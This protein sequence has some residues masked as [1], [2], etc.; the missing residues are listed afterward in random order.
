MAYTDEQKAHTVELYRTEGMAAAHRETGVPK[1]SIKRWADERGVKTE[2]SDEQTK[3]ATEAHV[4]AMAEERR[5]TRAK[6]ARSTQTLLDR[7]EDED[8]PSKCQSLAV[9]AAILV[10]KWQ[11]IGWGDGE[12]AATNATPELERMR[13][14][15]VAR[16]EHLTAVA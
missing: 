8:A 16:G 9:S 11:I 1:P 13:Q 14:E 15:A 4:L 3:A 10:D 12:V 6:L 2:R 7:I 5:N